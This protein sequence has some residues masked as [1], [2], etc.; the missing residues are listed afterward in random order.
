MAL[1]AAG[2]LWV[3]AGGDAA[4]LM[5]LRIGRGEA[6]F[7]VGCAAHALYTPLVPRLNRGEPVLPFTVG[8]LGAGALILLAIA[9]PA[10]PSVDWAV[11]PMIVWTTLAYLAVVT[12]AT[13]FFLLQYAALR[14]PAGKAMAWGYAT[15]AFVALYEGLAG[16][17][18]PAWPT[19][20]GVA[21][22]VAALTALALMRDGGAA[23]PGRGAGA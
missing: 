19:W 15:P 2:A 10:L 17:G 21:A 12:T 22:I 5:G 6:I 1:G 8:V 3:I 14:L 16:R 7:F 18:W 9:A 23:R 4:T 20:A 11:L 13:T